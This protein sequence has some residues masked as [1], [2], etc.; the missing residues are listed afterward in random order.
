MKVAPIV[1]AGAILLGA[2]AAVAAA[3]GGA[4]A[5]ST[6]VSLDATETVVGFDCE[7]NQGVETHVFNGVLQVTQFADG[8]GHVT[9]TQAGTWVLDLPAPLPDYEGRFVIHQS[10][11]FSDQVSGLTIAA[12]FVARGSDGSHFRAIFTFKLQLVGDQGIVV[13]HVGFK[14]VQ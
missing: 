3:H 2:T 9:L 11:T 14:C 10:D 7:G 4:P 6:A 1:L 5:T 13:D 8:H 12:P